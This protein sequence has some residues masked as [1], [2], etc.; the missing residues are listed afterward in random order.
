MMLR[1]LKKT[2]FVDEYSDKKQGWNVLLSGLRGPYQIF[3]GN[4]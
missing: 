4:D 3:S 1:P 2:G